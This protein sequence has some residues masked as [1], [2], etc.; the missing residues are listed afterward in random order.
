MKNP[1]AVGA[2]L[3]ADIFCG[4]QH[5]FA[6]H[7]DG[8]GLLTELHRDLVLQ[9]VALFADHAVKMRLIHVDGCQLGLPFDIEMI[10]SYV[11]LVLPSFLDLVCL[12]CASRFVLP[13]HF[14]F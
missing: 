8:V 10:V 9:I 14:L 4:Q 13:P 12:K 6:G 3:V 7:T 1:F 2:D 11:L 5:L